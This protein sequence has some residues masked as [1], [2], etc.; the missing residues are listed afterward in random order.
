[1]RRDLLP[2]EYVVALQSL[3]E[4]IA[5]FPAQDAVREIEHGLGRTIQGLFANFDD[6]PLAAASVAQV[7]AAELHDGRRV[8]VKVR[9]IGIKKQVDRDMRAL[10]LLARMAERFNPRLST[11]S[12]RAS[13]TRSGA[14]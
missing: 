11:T 5:P 3:Q 7:H 8:I 10:L 4:N 13:S 9:R 12:R 2:D 6:T 14:T 1:M